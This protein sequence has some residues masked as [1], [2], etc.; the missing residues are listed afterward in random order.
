LGPTDT[1]SQV[2]RRADKA[3]GRIRRNQTKR[4][5]KRR[6][7][8]LNVGWSQAQRYKDASTTDKTKQ[9]RKAPC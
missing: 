2:P 7:Q 9:Q 1:R 4:G 5:T 6:N 3:K 8:N